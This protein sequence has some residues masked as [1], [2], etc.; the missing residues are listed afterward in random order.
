MNVI[1]TP[2][3]SELVD[4]DPAFQES[5]NRLSSEGLGGESGESLEV[6]RKTDGTT[7]TF[8]ELVDGKYSRAAESQQRNSESSLV[9]A[10]A[11]KSVSETESGFTNSS[12]T[13]RVETD[14]LT[15]KPV[16]VAAEIQLPSV[17]IEEANQNQRIGNSPLTNETINDLTTTIV[18]SPA[19]LQPEFDAQVE[20]SARE[21]VVESP[22]F[23]LIQNSNNALAELSPQVSAL[24]SVSNPQ[25]TL[26]IRQTADGEQKRS[27]S[28]RVKTSLSSLQVG[29]TTNESSQL[30]NESVLPVD[31]TVEKNCWTHLINWDSSNHGSGS[32]L[33]SSIESIAPDLDASIASS[34]SVEPKSFTTVT[35]F[36]VPEVAQ[37]TSADLVGGVRGQKFASI[38]GQVTTNTHP[39]VSQQFADN[40]VRDVSFVN[41]QDSKNITMHLHPAELGKLT[42]EIDWDSDVVSA[43]IVASE[44]TTSDTLNRDKHWLM[45][46]LSESGF[47][48]S[49]FDVTYDESN[50]QDGMDEHENSGGFESTSSFENIDAT[51][52]VREWVKEASSGINILA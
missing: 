43:S 5:V 11:L 4:S 36:S 27:D 47:E 15:R 17:E 25:T 51:Q 38:G 34:H 52:Q 37:D 3:T 29:S 23:S 12:L 16:I 31:Q 13:V 46:S 45:N 32:T 10:P 39:T 9:E 48:L 35:Q 50:F 40:F 6:P 2:T 26:T 18:D 28:S 49:S 33:S 44:K 30:L 7:F 20:Q 21:A 19:E 22:E 14:E 42:V 24:E 41:Q 1:Q 8:Q